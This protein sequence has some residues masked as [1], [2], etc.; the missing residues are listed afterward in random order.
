MLRTSFFLIITQIE[1]YAQI[2]IEF[3]IPCLVY[4]QAIIPKGHLAQ[5]RYAAIDIYDTSLR[6]K[7]LSGYNKSLGS[8]HVL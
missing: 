7:K 8:Y 4:R 3:P 1:R 5:I 6:S 2:V